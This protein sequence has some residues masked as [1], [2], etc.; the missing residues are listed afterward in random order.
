MGREDGQ[1]GRVKGLVVGFR[2][3]GVHGLGLG[4][5]VYGLGCRVIL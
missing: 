4:F 3:L 5:R 2:V 1:W